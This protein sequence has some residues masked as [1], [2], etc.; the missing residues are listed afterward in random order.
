MKTNRPEYE[1]AIDTDRM[2]AVHAIWTTK[3]PITA[4]T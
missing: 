3:I 4:I 2:I 1:N